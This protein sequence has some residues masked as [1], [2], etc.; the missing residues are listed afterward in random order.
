MAVNDSQKEKSAL[1]RRR[2][3][4]QLLGAVVCLLVV[5]GLASVPTYRAR[6]LYSK[7]ATCNYRE[8]KT[9]STY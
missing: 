3:W 4:R 6:N 1:R 2:R 9:N 5:I 8:I 7:K